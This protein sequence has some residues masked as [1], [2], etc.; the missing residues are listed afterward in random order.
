MV[1]DKE[2]LAQD[3]KGIVGEDHLHTQL[4]EREN[5]ADTSLPTL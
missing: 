4:F 2:R 5:Y 3:L 1:L